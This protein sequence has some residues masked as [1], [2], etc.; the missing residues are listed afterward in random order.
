MEE[1]GF[2]EIE[3]GIL[4]EV[5]GLYAI[6][7]GAFNFRVNGKS[8]SRKSSANIDIDIVDGGLEIHV[9]PGTKNESIHIPV[10]LSKTGLKETVR[11]TFYIG[12][13]ADVCIIAGCGIY[14]CGSSDSIHNGI[15]TLY[16]GKNAKVK[17]FE[18]HYGTGQGR[19]GRSLNP[20]TNVY[21]EENSVVEMDLE[22]I[23]GVD[24]TIRETNSEL[25]DG[26]KLIINERL[27]THG[28]Q[29]AESIIE[30]KLNGI[31][32]TVD[33]ISRAVAQDFSKQN[34]K[35]VIIGNN[36]CRGHSKCDAIIMDQAQVKAVPS[37]DARS[38]DAELI[39]EAAIGKIAGEQIIKLMTLGLT[40]AEAESK[41]ING[42]LK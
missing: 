13:D 36:K 3:K 6:P 41:I 11:N 32:S 31:D 17:Y 25:K 42:F 5:A 8:V 22:Q 39:H 23:K 40:Q 27:M 24:S 21:A 7:E 10:I 16:V 4:K 19:G 30:T 26:A 33:I 14:N 28:R 2:S 35:S 1:C 29:T 20:T 12:D 18:K 37:L 15:H 34:F 38:V 9:K